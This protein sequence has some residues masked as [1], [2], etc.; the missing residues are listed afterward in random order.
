VFNH[1]ENVNAKGLELELE[2]KWVSGLQGRVSYAFQ[3]TEDEA[4]GS[5]L[6]NS[7]RHLAK[8]NVIVPLIGENTFAGIEEQF[9]GK[10]KT[11]SDTEAGS[12]L[13]TNVTL[14]SRNVLE[15]LDVS[16]SIYNLFDEQYGDPGS[17]EHDQDIIPQYGRS[18]RL[19]IT[20]A[21]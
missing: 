2:S 8:V 21:F 15:N 4:T 18:F 5:V 19:K 10:R 16:A 12:Y 20:Y 14:F 7:P 17:E 11:V 13:V 6:S 1:V 3:D 9:T